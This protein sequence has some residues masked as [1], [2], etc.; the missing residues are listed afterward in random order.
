MFRGIARVV[1][2]VALAAC[3]SPPTASRAPS[4]FVQVELWV[5]NLEVGPPDRLVIEL[6]GAMHLVR[7]AGVPPAGIGLFATRLRPD[8]LR[9][10][11]RSLQSLAALPDHSGRIVPDDRVRRV[12]VTWAGA[13]SVDKAVGTTEP[14]DPRLAAILDRLEASMDRTAAHPRQTIGLAL[15]DVTLGPGRMLLAH[16]VVTATGTATVQAP[17]LGALVGDPGALGLRLEAAHAR[18]EIPVLLVAGPEGPR[19]RLE[20]G[21]SVRF[22]LTAA[23]PVTPPFERA[24]VVVRWDG[25][26]A[27]VPI[28]GELSSLSMPIGPLPPQAVALAWPTRLCAAPTA[29]PPVLEVHSCGCSQRLWCELRHDGPDPVLVTWEDHSRPIACTACVLEQGSCVLGQ[30]LAPTLATIR[31]NDTLPVAVDTT[32]EGAPQPGRCWDVPRPSGSA[33]ELAAIANR[34]APAR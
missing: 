14:V 10:L 31:I 16:A 24:S 18:A 22:D 5:S 15:E 32:A 4:A 19:I 27:D 2:A 29:A 13:P 23:P 1:L 8:E 30:P 21:Q 11:A 20:P 26:G 9:T 12:R 17:N 33:A 7:F 28:A 6:D 34:L 3:S 25:G